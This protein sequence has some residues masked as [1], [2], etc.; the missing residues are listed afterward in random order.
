MG[1]SSWVSVILLALL[2]FPPAGAQ[3][4]Q[5]DTGQVPSDNTPLQDFDFLTDLD[6]GHAGE[7][8]LQGEGVKSEWGS[9]DLLDTSIYNMFSTSLI[10]PESGP[11]QE[12]W[13]SNYNQNTSI[14]GQNISRDLLKL[15]ADGRD[16]SDSIW[17]K[18]DLESMNLEMRNNLAILMDYGSRDASRPENRSPEDD[19]SLSEYVLDLYSPF[20]IGLSIEEIGYMPKEDEAQGLVENS[21]IMLSLD[22]L[23]S[24]TGNV[25]IDYDISY[26]PS[27]WEEYDLGSWS[28]TSQVF[29]SQTNLYLNQLA[30]VKEDV[31]APGEE[32]TLQDAALQQIIDDPRGFFGIADHESA[33]PQSIKE[34]LSQMQP[35]LSTSGLPSG[36]TRDQY[37]NLPLESLQGSGV[38]DD[39][40]LDD[41][42]IH[43]QTQT[44]WP[45][46][47]LNQGYGASKVW[48][49]DGERTHGPTNYAV[50]IG[51]NGYNKPFDQFLNL[52]APAN[53]AKELAELLGECNYQV[54][55]L[56]DDNPKESLPTKEKILDEALATV[57]AAPNK[58]NVI[59]YF[60][61]H[62]EIGPDGRY[63]LIPL[64]ADGTSSSYI[65]EEELRQYVEGIPR[66]S[67]IVD[68]CYSGALCDKFRDMLNGGELIMASS[69][70]SEPSNELWLGN[71]SVFT[72]FLIRAI[73]EERR[74]RGE[75]R[76]ERCFS[77]ARNDT[78]E[79]ARARLLNQTPV[80]IP[81]SGA[82]Y[83]LA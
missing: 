21:D 47:S 65:S 54:I 45:S 28:R 75:I 8:F 48:S 46:Q 3:D 2:M 27:N 40:N 76:L 64:D 68:A 42:S 25:S 39:L 70:Q 18:R 43:L 19:A 26:S 24:G 49:I 83:R 53:D 82:N 14:S 10:Y 69:T 59:V 16:S 72:Y 36:M 79:W 1:V 29:P 50:V 78:Q 22:Y 77:R 13:T 17:A 38:V 55:K 34:I 80:M 61:G 11:I 66:L 12:A 6:I 63:Y 23:Q 51:I 37:P 62:G 7:V 56:T 81:E 20:A 32:K 73:E 52:N 60:S 71:K 58:G 74:E 57:K 5:N 33:A 31:P 67:L 44:L 35:N 30:Q 41:L 4:L 15:P 9:E